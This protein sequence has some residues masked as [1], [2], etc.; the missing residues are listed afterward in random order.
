M[1]V[2][3]GL[4]L[5]INIIYQARMEAER[6]A[7]MTQER[8]RALVEGT[9]DLIFTLDENFTFVTINKAVKKHLLIKP[10]SLIGTS[11]LDIV[12][13]YIEEGASTTSNFIREILEKFSRERTPIQFQAS[14]KTAGVLEPKSLTFK[15]EFIQY[16]GRT[17]IFGKA[18]A[19]IEDSLIQYFSAER[20]IYR[21]E[22]Y[23]LTANDLTQRLTRNLTRYMKEKKAAMIRV[24]LREIIINAIEHGNLALTYEEK[25]AAKMRNDYFEFLAH[26]RMDPKYASKKVKVEYLITKKKVEY[27]VTDEGDGFEYEKYLENDSNDVNLNLDSHGRGI[28]MTKNIFDEISY[29]KKGNRVTLVKYF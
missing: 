6:K 12:Y 18:Q 3:A 10:E 16:A 29:N 24:A 8:Y 17:E 27:T 2:T 21:I 13:D 22:N 15:L 14:C 4:G 26:R 7:H 19:V 11:F 20:Q 9:D 25:T 1:L 28:S 23:L 5:R